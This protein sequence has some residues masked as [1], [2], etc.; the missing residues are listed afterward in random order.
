MVL[1]LAFGIALYLWFGWIGRRRA[2]VLVVVTNVFCIVAVLFMMNGVRVYFG[3]APEVIADWLPVSVA[4]AAKVALSLLAIAAVLFY[5]W[6]MPLFW[7]GIAVFAPIGV[8]TLGNVGAAI[9]DPPVA[10]SSR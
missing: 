10:S 9:L 1:T 4:T 8:V 5:K 3:S 2:R 6:M 7:L